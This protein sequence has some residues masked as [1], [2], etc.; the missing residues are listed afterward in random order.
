MKKLLIE[1]KYDRKKTQYLIQGFTEGFDIGFHGPRQLVRESPNMKFYTGTKVD[2]WNKIMKEVEQKH[3]AGPYRGKCPFKEYWVHPVGLIPKKGNPGETRMIVNLSYKDQ[4]S[5]N[6]FTKKEECTVKYRDIDAAIAMIQEIKKDHHAVYLSKCDG[7]AA[8]HQ[9]P[10]RK[11]DFPLLVIK[12]EDPKTSEICYFVQKVVVFGSSKSCRIF[13]EFA[14]ALAHIAQ[15][16]DEYKRRPNEYLDDVLTGGHSKTSCNNSL[17][18]YMEVCQKVNFPI[19]EEKTVWATQIIVF[20]GL[21]LNTITMTI[22]IPLE[23]RNAALTQIDQVLDRKKVTV[24]RIQRLTGLLNFLCRAIVPGRMYLRRMY[25]TMSGLKQYHHVKV[26]RP[27]IEDLLMWKEFLKWDASLT[28]PFMDFSETL[29]ADEID[30]FTD[31]CKSDRLTA[32][33]AVYGTAWTYGEIPQ[34]ISQL[35]TGTIQSFEMYAL[36]VG[37]AL[38]ASQ[39]RN[40]RVVVFCDNQ[41]V[42]GMINNSTSKCSVCL[43]LIRVITKISMKYNV[44]FFCRYIPTDLNTRADALSRRNFTKFW[45]DSP[46]DTEKQPRELPISVWPIRDEWWQ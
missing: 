3:I 14:A 13:S 17:T 29:I 21:L 18:N 31:A 36:L 5:L 30:F 33:G 28:R 19:S 22:A 8:F 45:K 1:S 39:L 2:L 26:D 37:V 15:H 4:F 20:L 34:R 44:R 10:V 11:E 24:H 16:F 43:K 9:L 6:Y 12:A 41:A 35:E 32:F 38:F 7:R 42:V 25:D 46:R 40:R 23:K 27:M